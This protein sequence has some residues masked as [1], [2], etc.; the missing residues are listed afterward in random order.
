MAD[1]FPKQEEKLVN[2]N[3]ALKWL[4]RTIYMPGD[5]GM[6]VVSPTHRTKM[7]YGTRLANS[8]MGLVPISDSVEVE[9]WSN[10][11]TETGNWVQAVYD[12]DIEKTK[13]KGR[14]LW[15]LPDVRQQ[16]HGGYLTKFDLG[17]TVQQ[18]ESSKQKRMKELLL[19]ING[20]AKELST[21]Q[22]GDNVA[23]LAQVIQDP[24][25]AE[26]IDAIIAEIPDAQE[27]IDQV[28]QLSSQMFKCGGK[29]KKK[30]KKGAKGCIPCKKLM[31][32]GGKLINVLTDCEGNIISK[33]QAGG[34]L[35]PKGQVGL[36]A[37]FVQEPYRKAKAGTDAGN[38]NDVHYYLGDDNKIYMQTYTSG[39]GWGNGEEADMNNF[40][41]WTT[42]PISG[43]ILGKN[44]FV[45]GFNFDYNTNMGTMSETDAQAAGIDGS[46]YATAGKVVDGVVGEGGNDLYG[47]EAKDPT[48]RD[49]LNQ[50]GVSQILNATFVRQ[51]AANALAKENF[52]IQR[53]AILKDNKLWGKGYLTNARNTKDA[54][55]ATNNAEASKDRA[56][57]MTEFGHMN[58]P[59]NTTPVEIPKY[60]PAAGTTSSAGTTTGYQSTSA[61]YKKQGGWLNKFEDGGVAKFESPWKKLEKAGKKVANWLGLTETRTE[62]TRSPEL[63]EEYISYDP[64]T[65]NTSYLSPETYRRVIT[66]Y[67]VPGLS[68][69]TAHYILPGTYAVETPGGIIGKTTYYPTVDGYTQQSW[70]P[71]K[72]ETGSDDVYY[73]ASEAEKFKHMWYSLPRFR[74]RGSSLGPGGERVKIHDY[75]NDGVSNYSQE[76]SYSK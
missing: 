44:F 34:W 31:R 49:A 42:T 72:V 52:R 14:Y 64:L 30:V 11:P 26:L 62:E 48:K 60:Q 71:I 58:T 21:K 43:K 37:Q 25:E 1:K 65:H 59:S 50:L 70:E 74:G 23:Y 68:N 33:H 15:G 56:A 2:D 35:I 29:T 12:G 5:T 10:T 41:N 54:I 67:K 7:H 53:K 13:Q 66:S 18:P 75:H 57:W 63:T 27:V 45:N 16:A 19:I 6:V 24:Q 3:G 61:K 40:K 32:V 73:P 76:R 8:P 36:T 69:D 17:G 38:A 22:P 28:S 46:K 4:Q 55:I 47:I 51:N 39:K 9:R 20:A